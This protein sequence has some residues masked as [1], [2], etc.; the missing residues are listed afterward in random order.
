MKVVINACFGGFGLSNRALKMYCERK[1]I[2]CNFFY[3]ETCD[4]PY[5]RITD[6][7]AFN[8]KSAFSVSAYQCETASEIPTFRDFAKATNAC[9][10]EMNKAYAMVA[11]PYPGAISRSD[12]DLIDVI[13]TLGSEANGEYAE[14]KIIEIPDG[15][16]WQVEEYDG[17]EHIAQ[18]H[19]TWR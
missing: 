9:R 17:N 8:A 11:V 18:V 13:E 5:K 16:D 14:L 15:I 2:P 12:P 3:Q 1:G 4:G 6:E 7:Q 10:E 19:E